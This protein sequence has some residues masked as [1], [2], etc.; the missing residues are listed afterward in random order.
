MENNN[1]E[2]FFDIFIGF[3]QILD[4]ML[5]VTQVSND[6]LFKE[7]NKQ[8]QILNEQNE[9]Y[10]KRILENQEKIIKLLEDKDEQDK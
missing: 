5:N 8:D 4:F 9:K 2:D 6:E 1:N 7:L 10:L 3:V